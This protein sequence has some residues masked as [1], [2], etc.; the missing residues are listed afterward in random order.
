[1]RGKAGASEAPSQQRQ[2]LLGGLKYGTISIH[3]HV[4]GTLHVCIRCQAANMEQEFQWEPPDILNYMDQW[5][6]ES[7]AAEGLR[8]FWV[9]FYT[10]R[11]RSEV[12]QVLATQWVKGV[13]TTVHEGR[14]ICSTGEAE[15]RKDGGLGGR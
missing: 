10:M 12:W 3:S 9:K 13:F 5:M 2:H 11:E 14:S 7:N 15:S 4:G 6:V 8:S 1:M